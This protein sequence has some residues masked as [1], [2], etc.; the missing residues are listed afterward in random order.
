MRSPRIPAVLLTALLLLGAA[1][2]KPFV[3]SSDFNFDAIIGKPPADNSPQHV[4]E[5]DQMLAMQEHR[6]AALEK[7]CKAEESIN[8]FI[9]SEILGDSFNAKDLPVTAKVFV[10]VTAEATAVSSVAKRKWGRVRPPVAEPRIHPCV[11]L[12]KTGSFPSGHAT[13][14]VVWARLFGQIFPDK[15]DELMARGK[16]IGE[17]RVIGGMHYPATWW[18]GKS[19]GPRSPG[20]CSLIPNSALNLPRRLR[21]ATP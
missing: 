20:E 2:P 10:R 9:F 3:T 5:V 13:R 11:S 19:W 16:Q 6:T 7:R 1:A 4:A 14:G 21:N 12:E 18:P 15:R 8:P 17:D